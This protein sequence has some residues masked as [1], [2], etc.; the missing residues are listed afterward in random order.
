M[1]QTKKKILIV[2]DNMHIGGIQKALLEMLKKIENDYDIVL[3]LFQAKGKLLEEVPKSVKVIE[4]KSSYQYLGDAQG[5]WSGVKKYKRGFLA[6]LTKIFGFRAVSFLLNVSTKK[7]KEEFDVAIAYTHNSHYK[8]FHG[9]VANYTLFK[10]KAKK[11]LCFIH[12][13]Y[14]R[15]KTYNAYNNKIYQKFDKIVC[16][17]K[18]VKEGFVNLL[19]NMASKTA[20]LYNALDE[21]RIIR[22]SQENTFKYDD[23]YINF[24]SVARL[25]QEKGIDRAIRAFSKVGLK[26]GRYYVVGDGKEFENLKNL[27]AEKNL[28]DRVFLLGEKKNPYSYMKGANYLLVPSF[29]E[30]APCVV[31]EAQLL[32]LPIITTD[33]LSAKEFIVSP[34]DGL[35]VENT[36]AGIE[37]GIRKALDGTLPIR[38]KESKE[39]PYTNFLQDFNKIILE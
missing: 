10:V 27:I 19:P 15:S 1:E 28:T 3:L 31:Q 12:C 29:H 34:N 18:S 23:K 26:N 16:V 20:V 30:A 22:L 11:K 17:S 4:T 33:T 5:A 38:E 32:N 14:L 37:E 8:S 7:S 21:K 36:D 39:R 2:S 13:D 6:L 9:G 24:L 35:V 25:S